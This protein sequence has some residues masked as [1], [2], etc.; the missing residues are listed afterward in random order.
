MFTL[1][2]S[3][4]ALPHSLGSKSLSRKLPLL[5]SALLIAV[6]ALFSFIAYRQL[7]NALMLSASARM[8]SASRRLG[9][10]FEDSGR[11]LRAEIEKIAAD[12][13]LIRYTVT[14]DGRSQA[15]AASSLKRVAAAS[16]QI[17]GIEV[18]DRLG[19]RL[20][21]LDGPTP[22]T[23]AFLRNRPDNTALPR[24]TTIGPIASDHG[25]LHYT[26]V[27]PIVTASRD[28]TGFVQVY[29]QIS[30]SQGSLIS[31][32][33]GKD[34]SVLIGNADRR[35][36]TNLSSVV[37]GPPID[38]VDGNTIVYRSHDGAQRIGVA[39]PIK[40]TPWLVWADL[41]SRDVL[42]PANRFLRD[43]AL[44]A[45][46]LALIGGLAALLI[47][48]QITTPLR[49]IT[50]AAQGIAAGDYSRRVTTSRQDELGVMAQ[51]FNTMAQQVDDSRHGLETRVQERTRELNAALAELRDAHES[52]VRREK[53]VMLGQLAGGVGHELRN[54]LG[55]M[56]N[57]LYYLGMVLKEATPDVKE[58]LGIL[59]T[60][61]MLSGKIVGDLLDFA[62]VKPPIL[63]TVS[64]EQLVNEQLERVGPLETIRVERD[65]P[66]DLPPLSVDRTQMGQVILNLV[67]NAVQSM[68]GN[69]GTLTLRARAGGG[70]VKLDVIDTGIG[71]S[72]GALEKMFEP[73]FT[74]KARGI[75]LGLA[76]S[77]SLVNA[78]GGEIS[79]TSELGKGSTV[80][81][82]LPAAQSGAA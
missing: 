59:R 23:A 28:T 41:P 71:M 65:L 78:N 44:A 80:T 77:R 10:A 45:L 6:L 68:D 17:L 63:E 46:L 16:P 64:V 39:V 81:V 42:T 37:P 3:G 36:W 18:N 24:E 40:L 60:Q 34:A 7:T 4:A 19:R 9:S 30:S 33:I 32:L 75:G 82:E 20:L 13:T 43:M 52:L 29:R 79:A 47:S 56:T 12:S 25:I 72:P 1:F 55:V 14:S 21:W 27:A 74:T 53:L 70:K 15:G 73:L 66:A 76:V 8:K 2:S 26:V 5:I 50:L 57:A 61:V 38:S 51:S 69:G 48:R 67:T 54:P 22:E 11:Q 62:R 58:Y 35:L 31:G 49:D